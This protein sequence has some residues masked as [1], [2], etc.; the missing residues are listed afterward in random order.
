MFGQKK[1][2]IKDV[3]TRKYSYS[4]PWL[5]NYIL[6]Q[7]YPIVEVNRDDRDKD[8]MYVAFELD[9]ET[10]NKLYAGWMAEKSER[11]GW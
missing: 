11:L 1:K 9:W 5:A 4:D 10:E 7:G 2:E 6:Q 8:K 3:A